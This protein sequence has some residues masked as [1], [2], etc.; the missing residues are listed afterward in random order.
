MSGAAPFEAII[1]HEDA[2]TELADELFRF[3][4]ALFVDERGWNIQ[5]E[6]GREV[7]E[8]DTAATIYC[9]L[10]SERTIVGSFRAIRC[11]GPYLAKASFSSLA[12]TRPYPS[13]R[14]FWE[15]SRFGVPRQ[16]KSAGL[17]LYAVMF[18][19]AEL[20]GAKALVAVADLGHERVLRKIGVKTRRYGP[21]VWVGNENGARM[22]VVAGEIPLAEQKDD[23]MN[24]LRTLTA[25]VDIRDDTLVRRPARVSA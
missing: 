18:H 2:N 24:F 7:D 11:D 13:R 3:R 5:I 21:P 8:F 10:L 17:L 15:I 22:Q 12:A 19:F 6:S 1:F 23:C 20:R 16:H 25:K 14:D 4:K 9:A